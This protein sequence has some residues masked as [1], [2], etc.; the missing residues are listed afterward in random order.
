MTN[1]KDTQELTLS[2]NKWRVDLYYESWYSKIKM[3]VKKESDFV[4][5]LSEKGEWDSTLK[6]ELTNKEAI[7]TFIVTG[8]QGSTYLHIKGDNENGQSV[9]VENDNLILSLGLNFISID[10][11]ELKLN[12]KLEPDMAEVFEFYDLESDYLLRGEVGIHR[13]DKT[14]KL[15]WTFSATDIWVNMEGRPEVEITENSIKLLD[16]NSDKY[17]IDFDGNEIKN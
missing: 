8:I 10:L 11:N 7:R 14:G 17:E 16:F 4:I 15:K 6:I 2:T 1:V 3:I 13:I 9:K 12:W 5:E